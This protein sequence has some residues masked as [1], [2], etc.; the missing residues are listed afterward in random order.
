MGVPLVSLVYKPEYAPAVPVA[1]ILLLG[2]GTANIFFWNRPLILSLGH[3]TYP[4]VVMTIAGLA[5]VALSFWL[6]PRFGMYA[7]AGLMA[8]FFITSIGLIV[9]KALSE[10]QAMDDRS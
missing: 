2:Y 7:Q 10:I 9:W 1:L 3:P 4:L 8:A 6:V 5:K